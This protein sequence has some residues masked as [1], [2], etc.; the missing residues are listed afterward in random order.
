MAMRARATYNSADEV[1]IYGQYLYE[2]VQ[3]SKACLNGVLFFMSPFLR[4]EKTGVPG[5]NPRS[6]VE[7]D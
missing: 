3:F 7:I 5:G 2:N 4:R 1:S 6:Q